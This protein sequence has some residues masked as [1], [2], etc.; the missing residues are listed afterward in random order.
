MTS[1]DD[2]P[3]KFSQKYR[4]ILILIAAAVIMQLPYLSIPLKW[5]ESYF[6]EISHGFAAVLTGG[7]I[8]NIQLFAN[9]AGLCTTQ[10]GN[11]FIISF[12]GYAGASLWGMLIYSVAALHQRMAQA[13]SLLIALVLVSTMVFWLNDLLTFVILSLLLTI[14]LLKFKLSNLNY[15]QCLLQMIAAVVLLN[16]VKSPLYLIDGQ[17]LGDGASLAKLTLIPEIFWVA[18]WCGLGLLAIFILV[19]TKQ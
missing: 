14:T 15:F 1:A 6:H 16:S 11:A 13:L 2:S 7:R 9:G 17:A 19:K 10:G 8:V 5:F 12:F 18:I 4:F 3:R